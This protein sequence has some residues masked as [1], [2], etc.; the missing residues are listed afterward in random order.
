MSEGKVYPVPAEWAKRAFI[1]EPK[2]EEMYRRSVADPEGFWREQAKRIDWIRPFTKVKNTDFHAPV[3][4][5]WYEDG[6]L[7]V[8]ANCLDRHLKTRGDQ[9][10]IIFEGDDPSVSRKITY[11][12]LHAE[13]CRFANVL[14]ALGAPASAR[15]IRWSSAASR[16]IRSPAASM[17]AIPTSSSPPTRAAAAAASC[18]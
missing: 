1:D 6:T 9:V 13:V 12:Q 7:N 18:P 4:I 10:A 3:S 14:K 17:T 8:A 11:R 15:S 5:K 2:Y 16:R